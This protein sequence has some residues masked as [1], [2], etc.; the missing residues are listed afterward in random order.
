LLR[1]RG[2]LALDALVVTRSEVRDNRT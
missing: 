2:G 1:R